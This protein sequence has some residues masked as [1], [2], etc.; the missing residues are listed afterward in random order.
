M[1]AKS[2]G[3][4]PS[5][6]EQETWRRFSLSD[7]FE[8]KKG[9]RLTKANM[10]QGNVPFIGAV[11]NNNGLTEF[12]GQEASHPG[13]TITVP[14]NG[15]GVAEAFYQPEPYRCSDD[16]NVLYP[17]FAMTPATALFIATVIRQEKYRFS[18]GRKWH[19]E[20][21]ARAEIS[22]PADCDGN[23]DWSYME[24]F[25]RGLVPGAQL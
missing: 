16:V 13:N 20:R 25:I 18:Y 7:L 10:I 3:I 19:L 14:Y 11:D 8:V 12:V 9:S 15:N 17:R 1:S 23:P 21:M 22:L 6:V 2:T 4:P 5:F 24:S